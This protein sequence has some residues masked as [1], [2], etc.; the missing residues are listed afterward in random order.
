MGCSIFGAKSF[1]GK[2]V[3]FCHAIFARLCLPPLL[4]MSPATY[5]QCPYNVHEHHTHYTTAHTHRTTI[6]RTL[7]GFEPETVRIERTSAEQSN[8]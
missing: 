8:S 6:A 7:S 3:T 1:G 2:V 4:L 5:L